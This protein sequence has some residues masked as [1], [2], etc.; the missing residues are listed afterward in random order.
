METKESLRKTILARLQSI[1]Q[2][3]RE[4]AGKIICRS[5]LGLDRVARA[6]VVFAYAPMSNE[7]DLWGL[8]EQL[9]ASGRLALSRTERSGELDFRLVRNLGNLRKGEF[10]ISEPSDSDE[11]IA[12]NTTSSIIVP[13][14]A[15]TRTGDR[16][17]RGLACYD[18]YLAK[19][20]GGV[21]KIGACY[22]WQVFD[23]LPV[24]PHDQKIDSLVTDKEIVD[25]S[26]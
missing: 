24:E 20:A 19:L 15:F 3:E 5:I 10:G 12:P 6:E 1:T 2:Q 7:L 13:G 23:E 17:G 9:A 16:L 14:L 11:A 18:R 22:S 8:L 21:F 4:D 26:L 25:I